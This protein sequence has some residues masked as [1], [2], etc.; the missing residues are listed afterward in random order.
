MTGMSKAADRVDVVIVGAGAAGSFYASKLAAAGRSV[1]VLEAG[2][3]WTTQDLIS[4]SLWSRRLKWGGAPIGLEGENPLAHNLNQGS[5]FGGAAL[6]HYGTWPRVPVAAFKLQSEYGRGVDWPISYDELRPYYDRVQR[7]VGISGDEKAE[8]WRGPGEPYPMPGHPLLPQAEAIAR[9][10]KAL[11]LPVAPLPTIVNSR[12]YDGRPACIY[13]GWCDAGCPIGP[14]AN[15]L[16]TYFASAQKAGAKFVAGAEVTRVLVDQK[17]R[18]RAVEYFQNGEK[19]EQPAKLVILAA[20]VMQN[21]RILL[22][23]ISDK[24]PNGLANSSGLVGA[25]LSAETMAFGYGMF[26]EETHP[27]LG[28]SAGLLTHRGGMTH[29]DA[30]KAFGGFQWQIAPT[31]K[32]N[33]IFGVAVSRPDLFG[34]PMDAFIRRGV[35]HLASMVAFGSVTPQKDNRVLLDTSRKDALGMPLARTVHTVDA[36]GRALWDHLNAFGV[37]VMKAAGAKESW[38]GPRASGHITGGTIMGADPKRSVTDSFGRTHDVPNLVLAGSGLFPTTGGVSPTYTIH[39]V[40]LR[41]VEHLL[42]S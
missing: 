19:R 26:E 38:A 9:G 20:S 31:M 2:P 18:A 37:R 11:D 39:A 32:P 42:D 21:P 40:A 12:P 15:P 8:I 10:F 3:A 7:E 23:S 41:S 22:N 14:L 4:S 6:H 29:K 25:Y 27:Y 30:P 1:I 36:E 16:V 5:G 33:D 34:A 28:L 35:K 17:G 13:D 24:H